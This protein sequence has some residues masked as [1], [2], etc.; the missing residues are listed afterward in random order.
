M[1]LTRGVA[2]IIVGLSIKTSLRLIDGVG[3]DSW[4]SLLTW[5]GAS[6]SVGST[7]S[8]VFAFPRFNVSKWSIRSLLKRFGGISR[9]MIPPSSGS[10]ELA[11]KVPRVV[12]MASC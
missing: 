6:S 1:N 5:R 2:S 11:G 10:F 7:R 4:A 8:V 9:P 3:E 12:D